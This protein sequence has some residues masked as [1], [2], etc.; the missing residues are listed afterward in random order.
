MDS[1]DCVHI[2]RLYLTLQCTVGHKGSFL[3]KIYGKFS[4]GKALILTLFVVVDA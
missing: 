2:F 3:C 1:E 4:L